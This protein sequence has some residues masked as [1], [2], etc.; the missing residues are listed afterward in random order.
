MTDCLWYR[1]DDG[2]TEEMDGMVADFAMQW[3]ECTLA[4][5]DRTTR[6]VKRLSESVL[7]VNDRQTC[8][9][10]VV[11]SLRAGVSGVHCYLDSSNDTRT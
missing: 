4:A 6:E 10:S 5:L 1:V 11:F 3:N 2:M 8:L 9:E 7:K